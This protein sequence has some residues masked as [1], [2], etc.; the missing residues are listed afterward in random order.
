MPSRRSSHLRLLYNLVRV[1]QAK[2][3]GPELGLYHPGNPRASA[4][5]E[6][7]QTTS[8]HHHPAPAQLMC[9]RG[10]R[11]VVCGHSQ[12]LQLTGLGKSLPLI[13][14][15]QPRLNHR[16]WVYSA[17]RKGT[18]QAHSLSDRGGCATGPYRTPTTL[19]H[20]TKTQSQQQLYLIHRNQHREAAKA[21]RQRNMAQKK[22][23]IKTPEKELNEMEISKLS[24]A[25]FKTLP[26]R[27]FKELSENFNSIEKSSQK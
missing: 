17:H 13:C 18:P 25:E 19:G 21:R 24:D 15:Q 12:S 27:T 7:L 16:R 5:S 20:A 10:W 1:L 2:Q 23:Q 4:R 14:Q 6:Q 9:H 26:R 8:E 22:E 3:V 11:L